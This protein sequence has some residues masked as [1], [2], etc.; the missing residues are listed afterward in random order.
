MKTTAVIG[1]ADQSGSSGQFALEQK[2]WPEKTSAGFQGWLEERN[3]EPTTRQLMW[4]YEQYKSSCAGNGDLEVTLRVRLLDLATPYVLRASYGTIGQATYIS[5][6]RTEFLAFELDTEKIIDFGVIQSASWNGEVYDAAGNII[7]EPQVTFTGQR[8]TAPQ[9][10][11]GVLE[12]QIREEMYEHLLTIDPRTPTAEQAQRMADGDNV[13]AELYAST[14]MLFCQQKIALHDVDMP[15][16]FGTCSGAPRDGGETPDDDDPDPQGDGWYD[17]NFYAFDY[18]QGNPIG[19]FEVYL[20]G[21]LIRDTVTLPAGIEHQ[22]RV[23]AAGYTPSDEDDL[24]DNDT[25]TLPGKTP[26]DY[27]PEG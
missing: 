27:V 8:A 3:L 9:P 17:V 25:F 16:N 1:F 6:G 20:N 15:D 14:A 19:A 24:A 21:A 11:Y 4:Y 7:A 13:Y 18:C 26:E 23:V 5:E 12:V 22:I 2:P 10:V